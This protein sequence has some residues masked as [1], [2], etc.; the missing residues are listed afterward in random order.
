MSVDDFDRVLARSS[1]LRMALQAFTQLTIVQLGQ[2]VAC[3]RSHRAEQRACRWLL[4]TQDRVGSGEFPL[5]QDFLA[6]M[7]GVRRATV[8]EIAAP[9]QA[10]GLI[11]YRRGH[12]TILDRAGLRANACDCYETIRAAHRW[13]LHTTGAENADPNAP[14]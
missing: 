1:H 2:N 3:N 7:L 8:S 5:T 6:Q 13:L 14:S 4:T 11:R 9:L 10:S 12:V